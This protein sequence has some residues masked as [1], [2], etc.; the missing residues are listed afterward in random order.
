MVS[1]V[2]VYTFVHRNLHNSENKHGSFDCESGQDLD[3]SS[4]TINILDDGQN[5]RH[6]GL[7]PGLMRRGPPAGRSRAQSGGVPIYR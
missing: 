5:G 6:R 3:I 4:L 7:R 1:T 2:L